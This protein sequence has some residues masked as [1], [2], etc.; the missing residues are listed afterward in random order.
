MKQFKAAHDCNKK[1]HFYII[2]YCSIICVKRLL[3]VL[4]KCNMQTIM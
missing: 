1:G 3:C 2:I 4:A